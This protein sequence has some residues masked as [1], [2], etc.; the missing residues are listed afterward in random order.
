MQLRLDLE[1][2]PASRPR[3]SRGRVYYA[4]KYSRFKAAARRL[5]PA[6]ADQAG[7]ERPLRCPLYVDVE[8]HV[9]KPKST[10]LAKP[11]PDVDNYAKAALDAGNGILWED[12]Y[13]IVDLRV[14]KHWTDG[15]GYIQYTIERST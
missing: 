4:P 11:K 14:S 15:P 3:M 13:L 7:I 1:P 10:K 9:T 6:V 8:I 12:D 2:A 5:M